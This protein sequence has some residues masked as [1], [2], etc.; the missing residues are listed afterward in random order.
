MGFKS[1]TKRQFKHDLRRGLGSCYIELK[2]CDSPEKYRDD[3]MW[4]CE[5]A[6]AYDTQSEGTRSPYLF[7]LIKLLGDYPD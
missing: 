6:F 3:L 7:G 1:M 5:H 2:K 4:G